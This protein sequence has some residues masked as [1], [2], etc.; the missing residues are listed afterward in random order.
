MG[1]RGRVFA[2][3]RAVP[4]VWVAITSAFA[5]IVSARAQAERAIASESSS[6][7]ACWRRWR[8]ASR[9]YHLS[10]SAA[11][12]AMVA[13]ASTG[14]RPMAV[15]SDNITASVPS[16]TAL[17]TSVTSARVGRGA[18]VM[19]LSICVAV[20]TGLPAK[21]AFSMIFRCAVGTCSGGISTPRSPRATMTPSTAAMIASSWSRASCFS[22]LAMSG[23]WR[24]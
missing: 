17:V 9:E 2:A 8:Q 19:L 4:P 22:I 1:W 20:M 21:L 16:R 23:H 3:R 10:A 5:P 12:R 15:S 7:G 11:I 14:K 6:G 13:T 24:P 18:S